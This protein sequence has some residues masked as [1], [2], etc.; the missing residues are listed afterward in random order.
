MSKMMKNK[1]FQKG[2]PEGILPYYKIRALLS[3]YD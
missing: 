2:L 1:A 3:I